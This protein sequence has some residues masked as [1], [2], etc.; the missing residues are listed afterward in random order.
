LVCEKGNYEICKLLVDAGCDINARNDNKSSLF[1]AC[2]NGYLEIA[3]V[4]LAAGCDMETMT[5][6]GATP[7][8]EACRTGNYEI[9]RTLLAAGCNKEAKTLK[10]GN[11]ALRFAYANGH[12]LNIDIRALR[13]E[14]RKFEFGELIG[15]FT[16][17]LMACRNGHLE[18]CKLLVEAGCNKEAKD[19]VLGYTPLMVAC[20]MGHIEL[21]KYLLTVGCDIEAKELY[22]ETSLSIA[23]AGFETDFHYEFRNCEESP[24]LKFSTSHLE[25]IKVLLA[26]GCNMESK[27]RDGATPLIVACTHDNLDVC[28]L[29]LAA[30]CNKEAKRHDGYNVLMIGAWRGCNLELF[31]VLIDAGCDMEVKDACGETVLHKASAV[32][33]LDAIK[34][35]DECGADLFSKNS[36]G[37][38]GFDLI[39]SRELICDEMRIY[40]SEAMDA[41]RNHGFKRIRM[42][43]ENSEDNDVEKEYGFSSR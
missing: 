37:K 5:E 28:N 14:E 27:R 22:E 23:C 18:V 8:L 25:I 15:G 32:G 34:L 41:R 31:K 19:D 11:S 7:F 2:T 13:E 1:L 33:N 6:F 40:L 17:F 12:D 35:L 36:N 16:P 24:S 30:G 39:P 38:T 20:S 10:E 43:D 4:L 9:C 29:L 26:A 3:D 42:A 21:V